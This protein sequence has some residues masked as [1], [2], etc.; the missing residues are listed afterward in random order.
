M[1]R[2]ILHLHVPCH[3]ASQRTG[4]LHE[5]EVSHVDH[6]P[7]SSSHG[8]KYPKPDGKDFFAI[9]HDVLLIVEEYNGDEKEGRQ[10][11]IIINKNPG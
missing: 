10:H 7:K 3:V 11:R 8:H 5:R 6:E 9:Y 2:K 1:P 4:V